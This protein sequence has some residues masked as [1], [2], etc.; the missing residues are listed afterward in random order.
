LPVEFLLTIISS[1]VFG[2]YQYL[3]T[4]NFS[5]SEQKN[6]INKAYEMIW[7]MIAE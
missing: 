7:D 1:H 4:G 3:T 2:V 6:V 5:E